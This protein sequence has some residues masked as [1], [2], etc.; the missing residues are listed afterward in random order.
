MDEIRAC[1][2]FDPELKVYRVDDKEKPTLLL[3]FSVILILDIGMAYYPWIDRTYGIFQMPPSFNTPCDVHLKQA[4]SMHLMILCFLLASL[5]IFQDWSSLG[6]SRIL[7][8]S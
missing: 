6:T 4:P 1:P 3:V 2:Q 7:F 5:L 8:L